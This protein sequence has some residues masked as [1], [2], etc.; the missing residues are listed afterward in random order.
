MKSNRLVSGTAVGTGGWTKSVV[1]LGMSALLGA[2]VLLAGCGGNGTPEEED[3][4][5]GFVW[6]TDACVD[7]DECATGADDCAENATCTNNDGAYSCQCNAGYTGTG[8]VCDDIDE[9]TA[10]TDDCADVAICTNTPGSFSCACPTGWEGDGKTCRDQNECLG[11]TAGCDDNAECVN[12]DGS[13]E[14]V[15]DVG[16]E[17]DGTTCSDVDECAAGTDSCDENAQCANTQGSFGCECNAGWEGD[18]TSC[19]DVDECTLETDDC[20]WEAVCQNT[21]GS[22]DCECG[23]GL[24]GDGRT[25]T[26]AANWIAVA[27][28]GSGLGMLD[29][30]TMVVHGPFL[31]GRLGSSGGGNFD[32]VVTPDGTTALISAFGDMY[33][34]IV[35]I[36][37]VTE[38][39]I[40]G[41]LRMPMFA[42]DIAISPDGKYALVTDGGFNPYIIVIDIAARTVVNEFAQPGV[43]CN[44]VDIAP[45]GTVI[46]ANYFEGSISTF[47]LGNDGSLTWTATHNLQDA[48]IRPV[49]VA[50]A[51]DGKTVVVPGVSPYNTEVTPLDDVP[52]TTGFALFSMKVF[53]ITAPGVL[54]FRQIVKDLPRAVQSMAFDR[55]G[56]RLYM[57]GNNGQILDKPEEETEPRQEEM[58]LLMVANIE[59]PG[60]VTFD[61]E[62]FGNLGRY[63]GSQLFGVDSLVVRDNTAWAGYS[64]LSVSGS[65]RTV[66]SVNLDTF[67]VVRVPT[68]GVIAGLAKVPLTATVVEIPEGAATCAGA[69]LE[70]KGTEL[71][72]AGGFDRD[73]RC[74]CDPDCETWGDCCPDFR[75]VCDA[76]DPT[77]CVSPKVCANSDTGV[78]ECGCPQGTVENAGACELE[79]LCGAEGGDTL[80]AE[81]ATC[82]NEL[83]VGYVCTCA[84]PYVQDGA[85]GCMCPWGTRENEGACVNIDECAEDLDNCVGLATCVD[86]EGYWECECPT[87]PAPGFIHDGYGH[88]VCPYGYR[89]NGEGV[90]I[91]IDECAEEL[92]NCVGI[93]TCVDTEGSWKCECPTEPAPGFLSDGMGGCVCPYGYRDNGEGA[94]IDIDECAEELDDCVDPAVCE[95]IDGSFL[96]QDPA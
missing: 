9:C 11:G 57:L 37:D 94:C 5:A 44:A 62:H 35:D 77:S 1:R 75:T 68:A 47:V 55:A 52:D 58:D 60:V 32:V 24:A 79:N 28:N 41:N 73:Q 63:S 93:A 12:T 22:F 42:E 2:A 92:D 59:S 61:P 90:C 89:D 64:T 8:A 30:D 82:Q 14:C 54:E 49:N 21:D 86:T 74:F 13:Y 96:C 51:P 7:I 27:Y 34:Y 15:C 83:T 95:D 3:C 91:D 40:L 25:C 45:D 70:G 84:A 4:D 33:I 65:A 67:E 76:C 88:C 81:G 31:K 80:C 18:G 66:A 26:D 53:E 72:I 85:D 17:G 16:W 43:Y 56:T 48:W 19:Q 20:S 69:C 29:T 78:F 10:A 46:T 36:S 6:D 50:V 71:F 87:E 23:P 38:P 39:V